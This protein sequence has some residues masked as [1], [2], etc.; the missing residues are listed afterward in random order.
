MDNRKK[1]YKAVLLGIL[2]MAVMD[3]LLIGI[4]LLSFSFF[5][6]VL[7]AIESEREAQRL[8]QQ[9]PQETTFD[10]QP[11]PPE[12]SDTQPDSTDPTETEPTEPPRPKTEWQLKF[13]EHF[14]DEVVITENSY[15][16]PY[17]SITIDRVSYGS[18]WTAVTYYVA[19]IYVASLD[20]FKTYTAHNEMSYFSKQDVLE[21]DAECGAMLS[22]SGDFYSYQKTGFL[23]RNGYLYKSDRTYCDICVLYDNGEL[24]TYPRDGYDHQE[25]LDRGAVQIWNFGPSLLDEN[26]KVLEKYKINDHIAS[27]NPRSGIGYYEPGHYCL[28]VVDG[29]DYDYSVGISIPKFAKIFEEL[30]CKVA[31]NLDGG[32]SAVMVFDDKLHSCPSED[33]NLSDIVIVVDGPPSEQEE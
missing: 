28:V 21:M 14:T 17:V 4:F 23:M 24:A 3:L 26:G 27:D 12:I 25:I 8:E 5:H 29:R 15:T 7:P 6:H 18:G 2:P 9:N 32:G 33:R 31:Y 19:D 22:V 11:L 10:T 20:N 16:S 30:G 1:D 13:A